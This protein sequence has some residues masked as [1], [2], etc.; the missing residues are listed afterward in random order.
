MKVLI[1]GSSGLI[2]TALT[3]HLRTQGHQVVPLVR[4]SAAA[5]EVRWDPAAG[6]ID[7]DALRRV[8]VDGVVHLAGAGIGDKRWS[9]EYR[10]EIL[11]SRTVTTDLLS[12]SLA[13]LPTPPRVMVS[14][15]AIGWYGDRGDEVLDETSAGSTGFLPEVC[16]AWEAATA[17]A[18]A[19]GIRV[20]HVRTGIVLSPDGGA[21]RKLLPLFRLGLGGHFGNGRQWQS[22]ISITDEVRAIEHL[23]TT[24]VQGAVNLTAPQPV[25]NRAFTKVLAH[26]LHRP[27]ILPI[28]SFGPKLLLGADLADA[29]LFTGQRVQPTRLLASGFEFRHATLDA[30]LRAVLNK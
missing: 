5:G 21:L 2:G 19:A 17:P 10:R 14:G 8:G 11:E 22:W 3:S 29:L 9:A 24:D 6:T 26:V 23:L 15:S 7:S 12:R 18:E 20:A 25:D 28:P 4:R 30:A 27:A 1:S 13:A 16:Q